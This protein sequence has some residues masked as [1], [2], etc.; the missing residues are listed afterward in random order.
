MSRTKVYCLVEGFSEAN[1]VEVILAPHL[2]D[3]GIDLYAPMVKTRRDRKA[4]KVYKG[5]GDTMHHYYNDLNRLN[6]QF[7]GARTVWFTTMLDVYALPGDFPDRAHGLTQTN[8]AT[9]VAT[10]E[11]AFTKE[12]RA[13]GITNFFPYLALHEFETLLFADLDALGTLFLDKEAEIDQLKQ[14]VADISCIEAINHTPDG[15]PSKR[16]ARYISGYED[17]KASDQSGAV[18]I[19]EVIGL[20]KLRNA[21]PHFDQWLKQLEALNA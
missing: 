11:A 20:D 13:R 12:M 10:L 4:G 17:Y 18:N 15:A 7:K 19:L 5:G 2:A 1:F 3:K 14:N 16:I 9:K 6:Q 21:S 8:P